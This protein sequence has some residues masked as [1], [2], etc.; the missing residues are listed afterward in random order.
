M[1]EVWQAFD[2]KL[3]VEVALKKVLWGRPGG[4]DSRDRLRREVRTARE[5]VSPNVCRIFDLVEVDGQELVSMELVD[6]ATLAPIIKDR[7]P[8]E[9]QEAM[10]IAQQFL[11]GLEAIH[12]AGLLHRDVLSVEVNEPVRVGVPDAPYIYVYINANCEHC[13]SLW[14]TFKGSVD[15]GMLQLRLIPA[16]EKE[17]NREAGAAML[18][19]ENPGQAWQ[20]YMDGKRGALDKNLIRGDAVERLTANTKLTKKWK[21]PQIPL[22]VYRKVTDGTVMVVP[23]QP[24]NPMLIMPDLMKIE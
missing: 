10:A 7:G 22:T 17:D 21:L 18:S 3:Q 2:M 14:R 23:G 6:G 4:N 15:K 13:Q 24:S 5:V 16:G 12:G 19:V 11:A 1:G 9:T 8:L 20:E